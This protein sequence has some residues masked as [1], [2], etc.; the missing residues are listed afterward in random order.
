[1]AK[2]GLLK[3]AVPLCLVGGLALADGVKNDMNKQWRVAYQEGEPHPHL[4]DVMVRFQVS[5]TG[6]VLS[7]NLYRF[8]KT[9]GAGSGKKYKRRPASQGGIV[10]ING[11]ILKEGNADQRKREQFIM[12]GYC[13][14]EDGVTYQITI[15]GY[16]SV[17]RNKGAG[18]RNDDV[19]CVKIRRTPVTALFAAEAVK[20]AL[21]G[22]D[23]DEQP[24]DEDVLTEEPENATEEEPYDGGG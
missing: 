8:N 7:G 23:C 18:N 14:E 2:A 16:H 11:V 9:E 13:D 6:K 1:M 19:C 20:R 21:F 4:Q 15:R 5:K 10:P 22:T 17:G 3:V 24:P 12:T